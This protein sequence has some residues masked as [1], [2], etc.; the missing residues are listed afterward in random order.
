MKGGLHTHR[1]TT[2]ITL[3]DSYSNGRLPSFAGEESVIHAQGGPGVL[4]RGGQTL[5]WADSPSGRV[6]GRTLHRAGQ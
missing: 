5:H 6:A 3:Q 1:I 4:S 2:V